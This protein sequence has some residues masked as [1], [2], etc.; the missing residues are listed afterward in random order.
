MAKVIIEQAQ[1]INVFTETDVL[2]VG[3]GPAGYIAA[4]SAARSGAKVVLLERYG[5]LGGMATGGLVLLLDCLCDGKGNVLIKGLV[6]ETVERLR[7]LDGI[8]EP[9][10][11]VWGSADQQNVKH[12]NRWGADGGE[13]KIV[14][15]SPVVNPEML[16]CV[17]GQ[18][19]EEA[20]VRLICHSLFSK[21]IVEDNAVKGVI[22]E[23]KSGR[24]AILA[25]VVIDCTGDGDVFA[26]AGAT[27]R[28]GNLPL[29]LIF[30]VGNVNVKASEEY[31]KDPEVRKKI[32]QNIKELGGVSGGYSF[33]H[34]PMGYYMRSSLDNVVWFNNV[35]AGSALN[36]DDLT[37][38]ELYIRK[39]M[40][41]TVDYFKKEV[42]GFENAYISDTAAQIGTRASR[43]LDGEHIITIDE[44]KSGTHFED[45]VCVSQPPYKG[46]NINDPYKSIP[47]RSF[48]P[49]SVDNL[50]VAGR[51]LSGDFGAVEMLRVIPTAMLMGQACGTAAAVAVDSGVIPR[52]VSIKE[53]QNS[54]RKQGV[55]LP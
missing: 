48:V 7:K 24:Q 47:Y 52:N 2:V 5:H 28:M 46:F 42:P 21:A 18:M 49:K 26:S 19:V 35:V 17:A 30:R 38:T 41:I 3:G 8:I 36:V 32:A 9:P 6:E 16:K 53:V 54:L 13:E 14:R 40:L 25:K 33:E 4:V 37:K 22:F 44:L 31:L 29:G 34:L 20:G 51:C 23:S 1:T 11:S 55:Y 12:W 39:A 50:L 15:Y 43:L 27:F 45:T 10:K